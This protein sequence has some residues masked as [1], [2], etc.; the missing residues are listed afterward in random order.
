M[1]AIGDARLKQGLFRRATFS[2]VITPE[3]IIAARLTSRMLR[4]EAKRASAEAKASGKGML[5]RMAATMTT[6]FRFHDR[7]LQMAADQALAEHES[8]FAIPV[9][10]IDWVKTRVHQVHDDTRQR[11]DDL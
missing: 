11:H 9:P 1:G 7:Y 3:R 10:D 6:G 4:D 8:N 2:L 5:G